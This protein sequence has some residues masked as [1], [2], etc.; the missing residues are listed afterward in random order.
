MPQKTGRYGVG[1]RGLI[2]GRGYGVDPRG[3]TFG[4]EIGIQDHEGR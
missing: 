4:W 2:F 1:P 3:L